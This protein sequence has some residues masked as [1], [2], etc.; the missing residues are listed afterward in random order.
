MY[1]RRVGEGT[2]YKAYELNAHGNL[3]FFVPGK[4]SNTKKPGEGFP[5]S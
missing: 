3:Q 4:I 5:F 1:R 2:T